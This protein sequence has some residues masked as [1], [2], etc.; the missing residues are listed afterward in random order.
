MDFAYTPEQERFRSEL[1]DWL[2]RT[3]P[4]GWGSP[5]FAAPRT[6]DEVVAFGKDFQRKMFAAG[7]TGLAWPRE[8][9]GRGASLVEQ[10]IFHE[11]TARAKA[12][13][14]VNLAGLTMAGPVIIKHG[15]AAQK[16]RFLRPMLTADEIW[17]Q[18][19]SEPGAGSDLASVRTSAVLEGDDFVVNGQ[20][21]W[22]S[23]AH[24][25][26]WCM[27][28]VRTD[29]RAQ[30][31]RGLSF[32]AVDM[33]SPGVT[34]RPL[35]QING[36][37]DFNELFFENLRVP[38]RNLIGELNDGWS[39]A[40][41]CLMHERATLTFQ[42]QLQSR[43]ALADMLGA[44]DER[45]KRDPIY[46]QRLA[47]VAIESELIRLTAYRNLTVQLRGLPPGPEGSIEKLFWSEMY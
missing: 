28:L 1:R 24:Y 23:F 20:K 26:D 22:T 16:E 15:S 36:D 9:G 31:H 12:P 2:R 27:L 18:G 39:V 3:L 41:T 7:Y 33:R 38:R 11:E 6:P 35:R 45:I 10:I 8:Y 19:F 46:R 13:L 34:V 17:C 29:P 32:L 43:T 25:A 4:P 14:P 40:L 30:K 42:R 5:G 47:Q 21:V 44:L 37:E